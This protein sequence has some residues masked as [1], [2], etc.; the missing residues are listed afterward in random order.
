MIPQDTTE[1]D[2]T[3][4]RE[5]MTGAGPL[6]DESRVGFH[7]HALLAYTPEGVPLGV[8]AA[9]IW[10]RDFEGFDKNA[11][12]KRAERRA[13]AIE[14]KESYRWLA[15]YR[16]ACRVAQECPRRWSSVFP[17]ARETSTSASLRAKRRLTHGKPSGSFEPVK[18]V[19]LS[20]TRTKRQVART[21][22][23]LRSRAPASSTT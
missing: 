15:G 10:A 4:P 16:E 22:C 18:I 12:Q 6:N 23:V 13:K 17:T 5:V 8:V 11:D 7:D 20:W 19:L 14:E 2:M 21:G 9:D 1:L 3:R